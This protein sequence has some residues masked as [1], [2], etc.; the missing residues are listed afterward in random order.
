M[1]ESPLATNPTDFGAT[2]VAVENFNE[3]ALGSIA[4][5]GIIFGGDPNVGV[6]SPRGGGTIVAADQFGGAGGTGNYLTD[7]SSFHSP[8]QPASTTIIFMHPERYFGIWWSAGDPNNVLQFLSAGKV[9][10]TFTTSDVVNF[11]N[12]SPN[13]QGYR[14]DPNPPFK[15]QN[16]GEDYAYLNFFAKEGF[17]FNEVVFSNNGSTGFESDN[18]TV[19]TN[20]ENI[21]G[22]PIPITPGPPEVVDPGPI[23]VIPPGPTEPIDPG[24]IPPGGDLTV[25]PGG[26]AMDPGPITV[27]P[28]GTLDDGGMV[29]VMDPV[30]VDP[31]AHVD[32]MIDGPLCQDSGKLLVN[33][34][35]TLNGTLNLVSATGFH[36]S[37]GDHYTLIIATG[38]VSGTFTTINDFVNTSG[39]TRADIYAPNGFAVAYLPA[40]QGVLTL[41]SQVP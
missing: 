25:D 7:N 22:D 23:T 12:D 27:D 8:P 39:L 14:G 32:F 29:M 1:Q 33:G 15:G 34:P 9:I 18:H 28:G 37:A 26:G 4:A 20:Y 38:T 10:Q 19:A 11:I 36:V 41:H 16:N 35:V 6:Y 13:K 17:S 40:G 5:R 2:G 31:G 21:T 3:Q 30:V 24:Q